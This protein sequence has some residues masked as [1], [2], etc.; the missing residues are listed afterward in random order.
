[1]SIDATKLT[2]FVRLAELIGSFAGQLTETGITGV[3][4]EYEGDVAAM[5]PGRS[6]P[7]CSPACSSRSSTRSTWFRRR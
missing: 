6:A 2:P 3:R 1:M 5:K 4:L 7:P